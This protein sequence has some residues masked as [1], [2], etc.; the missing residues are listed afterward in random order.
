MR[1][2]IA[3]LILPLLIFYASFG[4]GAGQTIGSALSDTKSL[5]EL[6]TRVKQF[7][8]MPG[9]G[10][11]EVSFDNYKISIVIQAARSHDLA[12]IDSFR[13]TVNSGYDKR[14]GSLEQARQVNP[15][16]IDSLVLEVTDCG[17][18]IRPGVSA[19]NADELVQY[20]L[21]RG[22][23]LLGPDYLYDLVRIP[24]RCKHLTLSFKVNLIDRQTGDVIRFRTFSQKLERIEELK[25]YP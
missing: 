16:R 13:V 20:P 2:F 14:V 19:T 24:D 8:I 17:L 6:N 22:K 25:Y 9:K 3:I 4:C 23:D 21:V 18:D 15:I 7:V 10:N 11:P 12:G 5:L 1:H